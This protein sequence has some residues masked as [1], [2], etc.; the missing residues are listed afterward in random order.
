MQG[1]DGEKLA[2]SPLHGVVFKNLRERRDTVVS[3]G[4]KL[5]DKRLRFR[6][7]SKNLNRP[8]EWKLIP[9]TGDP[10]D[11]ARAL[12]GGRRAKCLSYPSCG[13]AALAQTIATGVPI[14]A[15]TAKTNLRAAYAMSLEQCGHD[16]RVVLS[17]LITL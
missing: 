16:G 11:A 5:N 9:I 15:E 17:K 10:I 14:A 3:S 1:S 8:R 12:S 4:L 6:K 2:T 7:S 13:S